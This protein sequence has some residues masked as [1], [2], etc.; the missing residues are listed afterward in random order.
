MTIGVFYKECLKAETRSDIHLLAMWSTAAI[1]I[2]IWLNY[3][4][5]FKSDYIQPNVQA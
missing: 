2:L 4:L 1:V 3:L 5:L